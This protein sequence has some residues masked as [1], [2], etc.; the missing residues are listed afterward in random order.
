[1]NTE[2]SLTRD[3]DADANAG[4]ETTAAPSPQGMHAARPSPGLPNGVPRPDDATCVALG[5]WSAARL[6]QAGVS[7]PAAM[8]NHLGQIIDGAVSDFVREVHVGG[9]LRLL[10]GHRRPASPCR[11]VRRLRTAPS[12]SS[13][14]SPRV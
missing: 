7:A 3:A 12:A 10:R 11:M 6:Q 5:L 1:M 4:T 13:R 8:T 9:A 14:R 2:P